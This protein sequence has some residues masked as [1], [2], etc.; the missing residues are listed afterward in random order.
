MPKQRVNLAYHTRQYQKM[1]K[2]S[3]DQTKGILAFIQAKQPDK[4][5]SVDSVMSEPVNYD[6]GSEYA[7]KGFS[8]T[9]S[10]IVGIVG[11]TTRTLHRT[12]SLLKHPDQIQSAIRQDTLPVSQGYLFAANLECPDRVKAVNETPSFNRDNDG[13]KRMKTLK[14]Y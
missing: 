12:I 13:Y 11:K 7:A 3:R 4:G 10:E 6:R 5:Y 1:K 8:D 2:E 14:S 9:V